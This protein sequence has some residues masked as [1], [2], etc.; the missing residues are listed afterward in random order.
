MEQRGCLY[1][2]VKDVMELVGISRSVAYKLIRAMNEEL[3]QRGYITVAGK[4]PK[5]YFAEHYYG[6]A[7]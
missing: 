1:Y 6:M 2:T 4:V 3:S 7:R 5:A